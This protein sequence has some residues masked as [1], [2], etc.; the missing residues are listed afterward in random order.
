MSRRTFATATAAGSIAV[1]LSRAAVGQEGLG[2]VRVGFIGVGGRGTRL[3]KTLLEV[4]G[5]EV[6]AVCDVL[7]KNLRRAQDIVEARGQ[8]RP[9]GYSNGPYDFKR[10]VARD[11][12]DAAII[13]TPW[14]WHIPMS[15]AAM[16]AGKTVACEVGPAMT[17]E[18][19]WHLV[20][21]SERTDVPCMLLENNC[22]DRDMLAVL[23][24]VLKGLL[25]ELIHCRGGYL[26][27]LRGR[28]VKGKGTGVELPEGGD[29]RTRQNRTRN[30]DIY[31]T[32][33]LGPLAQCLNINRGNRFLSIA[34]TA[35]KSRGLHQWTVEN[36]GEDH[37]YADIDWAIG[38]IVTSVITCQNGETIILNHDVS[39]PRPKSNMRLVQGTKG[40]Y[41]EANHAV[42]VECRSRGHQWEPFET[43]REE[44][45]HPLWQAY[46]KS[47]VKGGH[48]GTDLLELQA[49]IDSVRRRG[50]VPIDVY[51][52]AAWMAVAPL[53]ERSIAQGG[54]PVAFPDFTQ[55][56]WMTMRPTFCM[57]EDVTD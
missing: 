19:C 46:L 39:L 48:G 43:Y 37:E 15:V 33:G 2:T 34:S 23:N 53:S 54:R 56:K 28:I 6:R 40:I 8:K 45:E 36:L 50:P 26:H 47:G 10:L 38:D 13:A 41:Q 1:S 52:M 27:D 9:A 55:G 5:V 49:F 32:H 30:G 17:V 4:A 51:D 22:Y 12:L 21:S 7:K 44:F 3:L 31:P 20:R 57:G 29:Y 18:S 35:T 25:G 42:H 11:D 24:M 14:R 16:E